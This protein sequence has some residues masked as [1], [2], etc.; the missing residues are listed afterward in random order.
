VTLAEPGP[1]SPMNLN[2]D[3]YEQYDSYCGDCTVQD[4]HGE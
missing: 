1:E 3:G 2:H 4:D